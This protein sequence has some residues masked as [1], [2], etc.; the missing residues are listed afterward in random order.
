MASNG[1]RVVSSWKFPEGLLM[2]AV[3]TKLYDDGLRGRALELAFERLVP[4]WQSYFSKPISSN[5]IAQRADKARR[6]P[7]YS[8]SQ[9]TQRTSLGLAPWSFSASCRAHYDLRQW[10]LYRRLV[11]R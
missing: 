8:Q 10:A 1:R 7:H 5:A 4:K 2:K 3:A 6:Y 9:P 11:C